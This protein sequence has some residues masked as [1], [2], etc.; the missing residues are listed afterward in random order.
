MQRTVFS[1]LT[2]MLLAFVCPALKA[3]TS[4][5]TLKGI[6]TDNTGAVAPGAV[7]TLTQASTGTKRT[8][9]TDA[10]GQ[11]AFT[12]IEPGQYALEVQS[13]RH[14]PARRDQRRAPADGQ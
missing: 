8:F 2:L 11:F 13:R 12:F 4:T 5:A 3:Q 7:V 9:T 1:L 10:S 14:C 6:V